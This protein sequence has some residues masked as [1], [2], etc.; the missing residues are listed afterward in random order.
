MHERGGAT[1]CACAGTHG[2]QLSSRSRFNINQFHQE[3]AMATCSRS[4]ESKV[5]RK[6]VVLALS[7]KLEV[8]K[9]LDTSVSYIIICGI[10]RST[11]GDIKKN[12]ALYTWCPLITLS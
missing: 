8:I 6:R 3:Q 1:N 7:E 2:S 5:K 10:G 4:K 11:V 9:L 12:T